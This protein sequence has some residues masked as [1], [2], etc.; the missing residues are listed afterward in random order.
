[1]DLLETLFPG[2]GE[3]KDV[4]VPDWPD[5]GEPWS[6]LDDSSPYG[7]KKQI[8][9]ISGNEDGIIIDPSA[10]IGDG[11][12]IEGPCY[13]GPN[14]EIRHS[15][16][17]RSGSWIC[18]GALVGHSSE[19]KNSI[20][21]PGAKAPHFN[22]VGDSILGFGVNLG[23]GT[24]LSNVRNDRGRIFVRLRDGRKADTGVHKLGSLIGDGSQLGC[25]VVTNPGTLIGPNSMIVPN[26]TVRGFNEG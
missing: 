26:S 8:L 23:A 19:I 9:S 22:Y 5:R 13:I 10:R 16:Y 3:S 6:I 11:V 12:V 4:T 20:L 21:L 14:A 25:N 1:M 24:K 17:L 7:I 15:A 2:L 18:E